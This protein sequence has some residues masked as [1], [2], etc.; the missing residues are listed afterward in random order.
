MQI[1][2][3]NLVKLKRIKAERDLLHAERAFTAIN[4]DISRIT[5]EIEKYDAYHNRKEQLNFISTDLWL[6]ENIKKLREL[7]YQRRI[8]QTHLDDAR[9]NAQAAVYAEEMVLSI[10]RL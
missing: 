4:L 1:K 5:L 8:Q 2:I 6:I 10:L 9:N 3:S 7:T